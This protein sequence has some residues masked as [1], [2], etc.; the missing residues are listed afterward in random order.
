MTV[1]EKEHI[2]QMFA[3]QQFANGFDNLVKNSGY[4]TATQYAINQLKSEFMHGTIDA[5]FYERIKV[6]ID[7]ISEEANLSVNNTEKVILQE[8]LAILKEIRSQ[9]SKSNP[10]PALILLL[11]TGI[12]AIFLFLWKP[13]SPPPAQNHWLGEWKSEGVIWETANG[14]TTRTPWTLETEF[15]QKGNFLVGKQEWY[16][17]VIKDTII[18]ELRGIVSLD[19]RELS[20]VWEQRPKNNKKLLLSN[21]TFNFILKDSLNFVGTYTKSNTD[22]CKWNGR[23]IK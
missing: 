7:S 8:M 20:G 3:K 22:S 4:D 18:D 15:T 6:T 10:L 17:E 1:E 19:K 2:K 21:G 13:T 5:K 12:G 11:V 23:K 16:Y 9:K 14:V